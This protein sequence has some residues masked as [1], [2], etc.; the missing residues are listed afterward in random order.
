MVFHRDTLYFD[1]IRDIYE[2]WVINSF[3]N[4]ILAYG[5]G[6]NEI[7]VKM[8]MDPGSIDIRGLCVA[9]HPFN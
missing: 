7:C 2:A 1:T 4:L 8:A 9:C 6:E 5:G 3:L